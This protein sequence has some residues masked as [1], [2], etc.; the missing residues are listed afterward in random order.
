[1]PL[2]IVLA[3]SS[4]RNAP[5]KLSRAARATATRGF[6][7]P[8]AIDVAMAFAVSWKPLVKSNASA[9]ATTTIRMRSSAIHREGNLGDTLVARA[10]RRFHRL[11][12]IGRDGAR[13]AELKGRPGVVDGAGTAP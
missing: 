3:T 12:T 8:V 1:M 13:R 4:D 11:V 7:A 2:A 9:V 10:K 5:T 6:S